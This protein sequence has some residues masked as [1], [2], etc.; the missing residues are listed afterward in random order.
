M[1]INTKLKLNN[2]VEIPVLGLGTYKLNQGSEGISAVSYALEIGYRHIDTASIYGNEKEVGKAIRNSKVSRED[3]FVTSKLW[4]TDQG[5]HNAFHAFEKTFNE[6]NLDYLD[7]YLLHW[8][9]ENLRN[10]TW[11]ALGEIYNTGRVRAIGV[12]NYTVKHLE[13][14][15]KHSD[16][17]PAVNQVEFSPW[18]YQETLLDYCNS[19]NIHLTAYSP[20][21]RTQKMSNPLLMELT[22]KYGKTP[23]QILIR[24]ALQHN[25]SVIPKS[26]KKERI[27]ENSNVFDFEITPEDMNSLNLL[28]EDF[29]VAWD[30]TFIV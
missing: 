11:D 1:N 20:L 30:P 18:L 23:A 28:N 3:I 17:V 25:I 27:L 13:E 21:V 16:I 26:S 9:L 6:L 22:E 5:Y 12:S 10:E 4:N 29:R 15:R 14:L 8:P 19:N 7:L 2:G 24:W